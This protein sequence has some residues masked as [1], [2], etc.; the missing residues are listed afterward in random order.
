MATV[1]LMTV[2]TPSQATMFWGSVSSLAPLWVSLL[3][4]FFCFFSTFLSLSTTQNVPH[5]SSDGERQKDMV[6][7]SRV[8]RQKKSPPPPPPLHS[9]ATFLNLI[10]SAFI[11]YVFKLCIIRPFSY[12]HNQS[13]IP[14]GRG[15][16]V[17]L[18]VI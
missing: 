4:Y 7:G 2:I 17:G 14:W 16:V 10:V 13:D 18:G 5:C 12:D 8:K 3:C 15:G 11:F 1:V 6:K 9:S